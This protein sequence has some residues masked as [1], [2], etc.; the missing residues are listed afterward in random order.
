MQSA[1]SINFKS[2]F[3][4]G[5]LMSNMHFSSSTLAPSDVF[6]HKQCGLL[7]ATMFDPETWPLFKFLLDKHTNQANT[8]QIVQ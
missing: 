7:Q 5:Y 4:E 3:C 6:E 8:N 2:Y 1:R